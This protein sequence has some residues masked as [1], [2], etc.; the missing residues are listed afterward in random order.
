MLQ[1]CDHDFNHTPTLPY[2]TPPKISY[3]S[4]NFLKSQ[5]G[6]HW[7]VVYVEFGRRYSTSTQHS[8]HWVHSTK[9]AYMLVHHITITGRKEVGKQVRP[10]STRLGKS[11]RFFKAASTAEQFSIDALFSSADSLCTLAV[12]S[13]K[14]TA[15][16]GR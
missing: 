15:S 14:S 9:C 1:A 6:Y 13:Q 7:G 5:N 8:I 16:A 4:D 3:T 11:M 2:I 12:A 10:F